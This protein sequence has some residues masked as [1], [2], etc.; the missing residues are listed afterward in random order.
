MAQVKKVYPIEG[1]KDFFKYT[2]LK[3]GESLYNPTAKIHQDDTGAEMYFQDAEQAGLTCRAINRVEAKEKFA[4]VKN[5]ALEYLRNN[6]TELIDDIKTCEWLQ[7]QKLEHLEQI[8]IRCLR[9]CRLLAINKN[10]LTLKRIEEAA[11]ID[12]LI[13]QH[14]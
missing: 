7:N 6:T 5:L 13:N 12:W 14:H 2:I 9:D 8:K 1:R 3:T 11:Y 10:E 4:P